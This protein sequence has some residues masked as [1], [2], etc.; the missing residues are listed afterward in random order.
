M[1]GSAQ[2]SVKDI[3]GSVRDAAGR[4]GTEVR[5]Y[6]GDLQ[7]EFGRRLQQNPL[8]LGVA[9]LAIG[10]AVGMSVPDTEIE[11]KTMGDTRDSL[12]DRAHEATR[13]VVEQVKETV[14]S[15]K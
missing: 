7:N 14:R 6:S 10:A 13:Q 5:R 15:V 8:A 9:A 12:V 4:A 3:A 2:E 11:N 1:A